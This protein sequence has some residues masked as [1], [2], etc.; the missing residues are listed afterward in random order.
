[1]GFYSGFK[2]LKVITFLIKKEVLPTGEKSYTK[3][4]PVLRKTYFQCMIFS[5]TLKWAAEVSGLCITD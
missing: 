2:G 1:M 3:N 4:G 5:S